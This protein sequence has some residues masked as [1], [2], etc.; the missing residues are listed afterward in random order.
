[1]ILVS[2]LKVPPSFE[3]N[4]HRYV[5]SFTSTLRRFE[6]RPQIF[7]LLLKW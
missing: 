5:L 4:Q 1:M 7:P 3:G 2:C 6:L